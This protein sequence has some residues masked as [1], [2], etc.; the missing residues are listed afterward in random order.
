[1][2]RAGLDSSVVPSVLWMS[3]ASHDSSSCSQS[4]GIVG[5][6]GSIP[7][8]RKQ[9]TAARTIPPRV[10]EK[11]GNGAPIKC[12]WDDVV[13]KPSRDLGEVRKIGFLCIFE[14]CHVGGVRL[15]SA[16]WWSKDVASCQ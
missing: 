1:M 4:G 16:R 3:K 5:A 2:V 14:R 8:A 11:G 10:D 15:V 6:F 9:V 13:F 7:V 12:G